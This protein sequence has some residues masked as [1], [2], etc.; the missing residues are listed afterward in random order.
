MRRYSYQINYNLTKHH[1]HEVCIFSLS[2]FFKWAR[3]NSLVGRFWTA[4]RMFD[5]TPCSICHVDE[6]LFFVLLLTADVVQ[7]TVVT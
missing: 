7:I 2:K 6:L 3:L 1:E 5:P 4:G